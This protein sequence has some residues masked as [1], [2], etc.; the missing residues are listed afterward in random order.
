MV[1]K[2]KL[3]R[4]KKKEFRD[5]YVVSHLSHGL[6]HQIRVL[7]TQRGWTQAELAEKLGIKMQSAVARMEDPSYGK[8]SLGTLLRL[9]QVFD[10]A[11]STRF[12]SFSQFLLE[13][14]D[15]SASNLRVQSFTEEVQYLIQDIE[16]ALKICPYVEATPP[17]VGSY[18][19]LEMLSSNC[20]SFN[21]P[22]T[23]E[24]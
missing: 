6:A 18:I 22:I 17:S 5:A 16:H 14:E 12:V 13:R 11:L 10:V 24:V 4:L 15:V 8:L 19:P 20:T 2:A 9:A 1:L 7:R 3:N 23:S 21:I